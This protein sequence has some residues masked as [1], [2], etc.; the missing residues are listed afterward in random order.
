MQGAVTEICSN[1]LDDDCDG[2]VDEDCVPIYTWSGFFQP[3]DNLPTENQV[4]AGS[5]VPVKFSL[6]GDMGLN[7]FATGYPL[8][9]KIV[10]ESGVPIDNIE[11]TV[12]A[13]GSSLTYDPVT[14]RYNYVWK[15]EKSW[16]NCRQLVVKLTDGTMHYANFKFKK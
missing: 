7:I 5:A 14:D 1:G 8:S 3:V 6:G 15:T 10:C 12:N 13:G 9:Q 11:T 2:S 4:K 16:V